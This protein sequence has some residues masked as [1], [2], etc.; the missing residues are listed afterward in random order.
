MEAQIFFLKSQQV[1]CNKITS[2]LRQYVYEDI[3]VN[4]LAVSNVDPDKWGDVAQQQIARSY[5]HLL[6]ST[7]IKV[8]DFQIGV[9]D[10]N[11][12][13]WYMGYGGKFY[14]K[15]SRQLMTSVFPAVAVMDRM[16]ML[17][18]GIHKAFDSPSGFS[19][20]P[21]PLDLQGVLLVN[22]DDQRAIRE[23]VQ[24]VAAQMKTE[25]AKL[26]RQYMSVNTLP[27]PDF[28][29]LA[30]LLNIDKNYFEQYQDEIFERSVKLTPK[31]VSGPAQRAQRSQVV[32]EIQNESDDE[33][34]IVCVQV[35]APS[36]AL[37]APVVEYLDFSAGKEQTQ[38]I[39]FEICPRAPRFCPLAV[40][41]MPSDTLQ[42]YT[43][44]PIPLTLDV[45]EK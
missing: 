5:L 45:V 8:G 41:F 22:F 21:R 44:F 25:V 16:V 13:Y 38:K 19:F 20:F 3:Q 35:K 7:M 32:L 23:G 33:L 24:Q 39:Q 18:Q 34:G 27:Q 43:P 31:I 26:C 10:P 37:P 6:K 2:L 40:L 14:L 28:D 12:D 11:G 42:T 36:D 30:R 29:D 1:L 17:P 15:L 4:R 9:E